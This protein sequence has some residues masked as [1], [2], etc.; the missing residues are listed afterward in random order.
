[1]RVTAR[2]TKLAQ[3]TSVGSSLRRLLA[4]HRQVH[5]ARR[6]QAGR[7]HA[8]VQGSHLGQLLVNAPKHVVVQVPGL[9]EV[10]LP[11]LLDREPRSGPC[12][13]VP[14]IFHRRETP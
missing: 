7:D 1:M 9:V 12:C 3:D 2:P 13:Q 6:E 5:L 10:R 8:E 11:L 14:Q 4:W